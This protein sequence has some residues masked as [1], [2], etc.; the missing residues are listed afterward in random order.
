MRARFT[1]LFPLLKSM[2]LPRLFATGVL[3]GVVWY[4]RYHIFFWDTISQASVRSHWFYEQ[5]LRTLFLPPALDSGHPP[6]FNWYLAAG[7]SVFGR[8]LLTS[9]LLMLPFV[10]IVAWQL[11]RLIDY[12]RPTRPST[13]WLALV[14][15]SDTTLI[16]QSSLV[17]T[18]MAMLACTLTALN[19]LLRAQQRWLTLALIPLGLLSLR[20]L[21]A[22]AA[23]ALFGWFFWHFSANEEQHPS[24]RQLFWPFF[25]AACVWT[26]WY[27]AHYLHVGW[28]LS[29]PNPRWTEHRH[30]TGL[31]GIMWNAGITAW[32]LIDYGRIGYWLILLIW[33]LSHSR[34]TS[35]QW[36][37]RQP[38]PLFAM[39]FLLVHAIAMWPM[40]NPITH[41]YFL[42]ILVVMPLWV[43]QLLWQHSS[44]RWGRIGLVWLLALLLSGHYWVYPRGIAQGWDGTTAHWPWYELRTQMLAYIQDQGINWHEIGTR[45]PN[46]GPFDKLDLSDRKEGIPLVDWTQ[47]RY[48]FYSNVM[49][50]FSDEELAH[51]DTLPRLHQL[52]KGAICVVLYQIK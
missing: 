4:S 14:P 20:G 17:S 18:D 16:A 3:I 11:S 12:T 29:T 24:L 38:L 32:R 2:P 1:W 31:A 10:C 8:S 41:R 5:G 15:L 50:D 37:L 34:G 26:T 23:L 27:V 21:P 40:S 22:A 39:C 19:A 47:H 7:W 51:L 46:A 45:F 48:V 25:L 42:P 13:R 28:W 6:L 30:L 49:N 9:H 36:W 44:K 43:A 35:L 52:Q 33:L